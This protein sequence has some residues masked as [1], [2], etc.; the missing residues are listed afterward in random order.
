LTERELF[1][2]ALALAPDGRDPFLEAACAG[3]S[4]L[5]ERVE[6]LL[7]LTGT[8]PLEGKRLRELG[9]AEMQQIIREEEAPRPS[10]RMS[11]LGDSATIL[12]GN[13]GTDPKQLARLLAVD[14][15]WIVMKALEKDRSG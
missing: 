5:R 8:T 3:D 14:L 15:D 7:L 11:S 6:D 12:A 2:A 4:A 9:Y 10:T 1:E 13:R